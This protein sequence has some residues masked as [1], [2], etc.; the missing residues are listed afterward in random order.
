MGDVN[1]TEIIY[2]S[3][4]QIQRKNVFIVI[5]LIEIVKIYFKTLRS[6]LNVLLIKN[7]LLFQSLNYST[8]TINN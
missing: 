5:I 1:F 2:E 4:L 6:K 7:Q 8:N 3:A